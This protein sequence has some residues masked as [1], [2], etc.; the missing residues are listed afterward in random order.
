MFKTPILFLIFNRPKT[1]SLVFEQIKKM[2]PASLYV[3]AD[4]PRIGKLGEI[5]DCTM[6]RS[7]VLD[8]VDWPCEIKTLFRDENQGCKK[9]VSEAINWFFE[10][11]EMGIILEDDCLPDPSF[12]SFAEQMLELYKED[13]NIGAIN[14]CNFG[15]ENYNGSYFFS[16][17]MNV[18]GWGT[19]ARVAKKVNY[20]IP[21]WNTKSKLY[22]LWVTLKNNLFDF[23][24]DWYRYWKNN[25]DAISSGTLNTW[26]YQ[27]QYYQWLTGKKVIVAS[28][29]LITNIGFGSD[30]THT[31][32]QIHPA[33]SLKLETILYPLNKPVSYKLDKD[34]EEIAVK[35]I[36]HIYKS[37]SS[38]FYLFNAINSSFLVQ[39]IRTKL[40]LK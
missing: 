2:Q 30:A 7:I 17:Y 8:G 27:W 40:K 18:W 6:T 15:F 38:F 25:F 5:K 37:K 22:F 9:A 13:E 36:W 3:A 32:E 31:T 14:G 21:S 33:N 28:K 16:R 29:N 26:D 39:F 19:W 34:Y 4:G 10:N 23:D 20:D 1:T 35:P 11:N 24:L 12:F